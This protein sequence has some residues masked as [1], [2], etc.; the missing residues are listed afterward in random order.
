MNACHPLQPRRPARPVRGLLATLLGLALALPALQAGA[1]PARDD[2]AIRPF[3]VHVPQARLDDLQRR[4]AQTRWPDRELV[5][6]G[7]QG[8]ALARMQALLGYWGKGYDWRRLEKELNALPQYVTR[9]DG[10]EIQFI[11]V[12]SREPGAM[13]LILTHGW[14]GSPLEFIKAIGPL[15]DPV[16]HGGKAEDAFD[17]VIPAIPGYGFSGVPRE[18]GWNPDRVARAWDVLMKRLGYARYVS[19][20]GDHGSVI[21]DALARQ[22]PPGL[23]GIH[24]NMPATVPPELVGPINAGDPPPAGLGAA[25]QR[26]F[27]ALS[28]FFGHN[29]AYGAM[30]VTRPQ[31]IGYALADSPS[32]LA[33]WMYE[34]I[35]EWSDS[36]GQPERVLGRDAILDDITLY[37]LTNTG[38]ASSRFYWENHNNNFSAQAQQTRQIRVPVAITVFPHEIYRA[39]ESWSRQ[40]Y[41]SLYYFHEADKGGHFAA[42]EQPQLFAEELRAAFRPLR[43]ALDAAP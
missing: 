12:R 31:T 18:R 22:A 25:E 33:A 23:L 4:I 10:V 13:P 28:D 15:T 34:K 14:P 38:A 16:A 36:D 43:P 40:A 35:A 29:A 39:P 37:W 1:T 27:V 30:M 32:G 19:Q 24:L 7:S 20:G 5:D 9:I 41:P 6:D 42:W 21:S 26:A 11:H 8:I 2:T 17:V 3:E